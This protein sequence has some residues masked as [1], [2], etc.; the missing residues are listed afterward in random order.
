[1]YDPTGENKPQLATDITRRFKLNDA[2]KNKKLIYYE[3]DIQD[4]D[5]PDIMAEKYYGD[6]RLDW[7]F[8]ISNQIYDPYF[9]WPLNYMQLQAYVRQKY[10]SVSNAVGTIHHYE[11]IIT[12]RKEYYSNFDNSVIMIPEQTLVVDQTT[13]N[14]LSAS[15]RKVITSYDYEENLNNEKRKIKILDK[16]FI[17]ELLRSYE[18]VFDE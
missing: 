8:F 11:Q 14:S 15:L 4:H 17:P 10:G 18:K 1:M 6:S 7:I 3:Y 12:A 13:Y 5:R 2:V 9:Q 16:A